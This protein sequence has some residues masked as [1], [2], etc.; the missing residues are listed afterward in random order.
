MQYGDTAV[1]VAARNGH[2]SVVEYLVDRGADIEAKDR[3]RAIV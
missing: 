2:L 3:V 1:M